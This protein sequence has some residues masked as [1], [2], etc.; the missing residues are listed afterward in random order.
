MSHSVLD[1]PRRRVLPE[2]RPPR[3]TR[4]RRRHHRVRRLIVGLLLVGLGLSTASYVRALT[5]PG[6][7]TWQQRSVSWVRDHGG[8]PIVN[9][10]ENWYYTRN[11]PSTAPPNPAAL[12]TTAAPAATPAGG[13]HPLPAVSGLPGEGAWVP[14]RAGTGGQP[15]AY[16]TYVQ[17]DPAHAGVVA[18]VAWIRVGATTAHLVAGTTQPGGNGWAGNA[19]VPPAAVP[20][21]VA[22][23]NSGFKLNDITGGYYSHGRTAKALRTGQASL[24]VNDRGAITIGQ[25]GRDITMNPHI[26]SVRQ[27]LALVVDHGRAADGLTVNADQRWGSAA[28]QL[29]Y[30]WR[31]RIGTDAAGNLIYVAGDKMTLATL[32]GALIDAGAVTGMQ[33]D[34]HPGMAFYASWSPTGAQGAQPRK[35]LP[36]MPGAA[37]RY[38]APDQRDFFYLTL[39]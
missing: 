23:F 31:S 37:H 14:G 30:T 22:V 5:Y 3:P 34:I 9:R 13:P 1:P 16:T 6:N 35:L 27:N 25:W 39:H 17:P 36:T 33:L 8:S 12:P 26:A 7:A 29:Q 21:L 15:V 11:A 38:L 19:Q 28:N 10:A 32:A 18:G 2:G 24:V 4:E 20:N